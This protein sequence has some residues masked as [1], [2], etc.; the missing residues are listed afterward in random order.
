MVPDKHGNIPFVVCSRNP[1]G[2]VSV[3]TL[4]RTSAASCH[5]PECDIRIQAPDAS[6]FG[7]FGY[8][9]SLQITGNFS[10]KTILA[11]D[12]AGDSAVNI[13]RLVTLSGSGLIIS[14]DVISTIGTLSQQ[15][16]DTSEP[17][18]VLKIV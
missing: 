15:E 14:G 5:T 17:G 6:C 2:A 3:A 1:N 4:C 12:L 16:D 9:N 10:G 7:I 8:Y 18:L 13:T 11:Q